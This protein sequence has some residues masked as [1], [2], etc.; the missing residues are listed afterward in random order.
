MDVLFGEVSESEGYSLRVDLASQ[1]ITK[2]DGSTVSFEIDGSLKER[3][4]K[5][6]DQIG[7]TLRHE[8]R[9]SAYEASRG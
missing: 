6:W 1:T 5:G 4:L 9:I 3:L 2:P 8:D 7:L